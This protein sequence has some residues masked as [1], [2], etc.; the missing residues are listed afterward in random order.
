MKTYTKPSLTALGPLR[1]VTKF[2]GQVFECWIAA[3][4]FDENIFTGPRVIKVRTWLVN[5][6]EPSS[7]VA[8]FVMHLYRQYGERVAKVIKQNSILK[9]GFRKLFDKALA[10]AEAKYGKL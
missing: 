1:S 3:A 9:R 6:F 8:R 7:M 2:S 5:D 4:V 10:K